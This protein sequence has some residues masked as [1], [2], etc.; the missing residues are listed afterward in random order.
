MGMSDVPADFFSRYP[1]AATSE[2]M[3]GRELLDL[4]ILQ[5]VLVLGACSQRILGPEQE[6]VPPLLHLGHRQPML[7]G[8]GL[9]RGLTLQ[10]A[11]DQR[12]PPPRGP[13]LR[14]LGTLVRHGPPPAVIQSR[15]VCGLNSEGSSIFGRTRSYGREKG[16]K[17]AQRAFRLAQ[18]RYD[19]PLWR[20]SH[21]THKIFHGLPAIC[22]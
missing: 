4:F 12:C 22:P 21:L 5:G 8:C 15:L 14:G 7:A 10:D 16:E 6:P 18:Y 17:S 9:G 13:A 19:A 3:S 11:E 20:P 1:C 2:V